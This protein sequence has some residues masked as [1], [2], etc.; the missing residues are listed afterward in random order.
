M[1]LIFFT[2]IVKLL[3]KLT[4]TNLTATLFLGWREYKVMFCRA[5]LEKPETFWRCHN[6]CSFKVA[7]TEGVRSAHA[8]SIPGIAPSVSHQGFSPFNLQVASR[9]RARLCHNGQVTCPPRSESDDVRVPLC[10]IRGLGIVVGLFVYRV[11]ECEV[12]VRVCGCV[13]LYPNRYYNRT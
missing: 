3:K 11:C 8:G 13:C 10:Y 1:F 12:C 2:N 7:L 9:W 4:D 5:P 6:L